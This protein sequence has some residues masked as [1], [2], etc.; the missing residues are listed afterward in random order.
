MGSRVARHPPR[1]RAQ[2]CHKPEGLDERLDGIVVN[3]LIQMVA[4]LAIK[5]SIFLSPLR[6]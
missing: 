2:N 4:L 6:V 3:F 1:T 5:R